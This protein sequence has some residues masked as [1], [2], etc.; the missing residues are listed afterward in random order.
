[1]GLEVGVGL[2]LG[3]AVL[4]RDYTVFSPQI[5]LVLPPHLPS[6]ILATLLQSGRG[7]TLTEV[8]QASQR[9]SGGAPG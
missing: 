7:R 2:G 5:P 8:S 6:A 3:V 9:A 4:M 1:M